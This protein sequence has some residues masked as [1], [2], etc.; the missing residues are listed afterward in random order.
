MAFNGYHSSAARANFIAAALNPFS[1]SGWKIVDR[2]N[3][4]ADYPSDFDLL[5]IPQQIEDDGLSALRNHPL[6]KRVTP[7]RQV[8]RTLKYINESNSDEFKEF[9][10][11]TGRS[12]LSLVFQLVQL[13]LKSSFL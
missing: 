12:S 9:R 5:R 8:F 7:Q 1:S 2:Q 4:A 11:F 3:L 10:R 6:I 13:I